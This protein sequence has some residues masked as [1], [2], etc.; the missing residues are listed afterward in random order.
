[1]TR[2]L[3]LLGLALQSGTQLVER[4]E[5]VRMDL[6]ECREVDGPTGKTSLEDW[7]HVHVVVR[8]SLLTGELRDHLVGVHVSR[9]VPR[10]GLEDVDRETG[11]SCSPLADLVGGPWRFRSARPPSSLS[12]SAFVRAA[13]AFQAAEPVDHRGGNRVTGDLEVLYGFRGLCTPELV[14]GLLLPSPSGYLPRCVPGG[15]SH[16]R[17]RARSWPGGPRRSG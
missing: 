17:R 9:D 11:S 16:G 15:R 4:R 6:A 3:K 5:E 2:S 14:R 13:A 1:L 7:P 12:S 10:A 8:M